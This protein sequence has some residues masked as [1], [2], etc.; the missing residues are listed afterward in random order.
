LVG[1]AGRCATAIRELVARD[2]E[3]PRQ[4]VRGNG[5]QR[6]PRGRERLSRDIL[7]ERG[8]RAVQQ[9][10]QDRWIVRPVQRLETRTIGV[11]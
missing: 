6:L 8:A 11:R 4:L 2:A 7:G 3:Q 5:V 1:F 9:K 10:P